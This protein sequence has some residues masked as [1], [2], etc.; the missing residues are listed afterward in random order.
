MKKNF[1]RVII[2]VLILFSTVSFAEAT[3]SLGATLNGSTWKGDNG[4]SSSEFESDEGG[5]FGLSIN[6][7]ADQFYSGLSLQGGEYRFLDTGPTE[8]TSNGT[9]AIDNAR[10]EHSDFD[11]IFGYYFWPQISLFVDLKSATSKWQT[12]GYQQTFAGLGFG[13]S[14]YKILKPQWAIFGSFGFVNGKL[15]DDDDSTFGDGKSSAL[16]VGG[17]YTVDAKNSINF[18][19]KLR[20]YDY[21]FDSGENQLYR[22]NGLFAGY[23]R[24]F[25][26]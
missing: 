11:L 5:Q 23:T 14:G 18:G 6:Y 15:S 21:D 19:L 25:K 12:N 2:P 13:V 3:V 17:L 22:L 7:R 10:V 4:S 8:F 26:W 1:G 9:L 16:T 24:S 20:R